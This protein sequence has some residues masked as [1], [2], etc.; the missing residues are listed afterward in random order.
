MELEGS[1][2]NVSFIHALSHRSFFLFPMLEMIKKEKS[3]PWRMVTVSGPLNYNKYLKGDVSLSLR[4]CPLD[5]SMEKNIIYIFNMLFGGPF[6]HFYYLC[7]LVVFVFW[8]FIPK[9]PPL[10]S[11]SLVLTHLP[12]F[13]CLCLTVAGFTLVHLF[14][15]LKERYWSWDHNIKE[16]APFFLANTLPS[17]QICSLESYSSTLLVSGLL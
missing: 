13:T 5:T 1:I 10:L 11:T 16:L 7:L 15:T 6:S 3:T 8:V 4:Y 9:K 14:Y 17:F 12:L 2:L